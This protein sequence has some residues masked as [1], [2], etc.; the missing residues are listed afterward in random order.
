MVPILNSSRDSL[1]H[2]HHFLSLN[3]H[4]IATID[5]SN[6]S[7][8]RRDLLPSSTPTEST[9]EIDTTANRTQATLAQRINT[10][11]TVFSLVPSTRSRSELEQGSRSS[12]DLLSSSIPLGIVLII[13]P[14]STC[15]LT[16]APF[17]PG[18]GRP[19]THQSSET[20]TTSQLEPPYLFSLQHH[21][22]THH[23]QSTPHYEEIVRIRS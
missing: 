20:T 23:K 11:S 8:P 13:L 6:H 1:S 14:S 16:K 3:G 2:C 5:S 10:D 18:R 21:R 22:S 15:N 12:T 19:R 7:S 4:L 17:S 9:L